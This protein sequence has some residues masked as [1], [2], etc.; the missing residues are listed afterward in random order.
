MTLNFN[1]FYC[2]IDTS[3]LLRSC[4]GE[5][6]ANFSFSMVFFCLRVRNPYRTDRRMDGQDA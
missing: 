6:H 4:P 3:L 2:K 1:L 5:V